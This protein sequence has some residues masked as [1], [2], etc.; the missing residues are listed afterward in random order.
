MGQGEVGQDGDGCTIEEVGHN[1]TSLTASRQLM[2]LPW[3][4][5]MQKTKQDPWRKSA[6]EP[7]PLGTSA[8]AAQDSHST[9]LYFHKHQALASTRL[10]WG[11]K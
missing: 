7:C 8:D 5:P 3:Q 1:S 2:A 9:S 4:T 10:G 11:H 6:I